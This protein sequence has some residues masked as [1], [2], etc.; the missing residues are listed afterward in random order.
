MPAAMR[1]QALRFGREERGERASPQLTR[2][3][4]GVDHLLVG[5]TATRILLRH[6]PRS[7][8]RGTSTGPASNE[9]RG[10]KRKRMRKKQSTMFCVL[11]NP[12]L[13]FFSIC[14]LLISWCVA[15][16]W[17]LRGYLSGP[18]ASDTS[19]ERPSSLGQI[20]AAECPF[21]IGGRKRRG[22]C[23]AARDLVVPVPRAVQTPLPERWVLGRVW[24]GVIH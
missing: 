10:N 7:Q 18:R 6:G 19:N 8:P 9:P 22:W 2:S 23:L 11:I 12:N 15:V 13:S 20:R 14:P 3:P 21:C 16:S 5:A 1:G 4:I 24:F 17:L